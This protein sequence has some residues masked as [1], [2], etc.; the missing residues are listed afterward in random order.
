MSSAKKGITQKQAD[1][2]RTLY[3]QTDKHGVRKYT[4]RELGEKY[5]ISAVMVNHIVNGRAHVA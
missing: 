4:Q 1:R 3:A 5:G 2:I